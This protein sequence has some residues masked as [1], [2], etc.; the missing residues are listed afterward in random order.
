MSVIKS[1]EYACT[2]SKKKKKPTIE[3]AC[4]MVGVN[5]SPT[6]VHILKLNILLNGNTVRESN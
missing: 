1:L 4:D 6:K 5:V 2:F 3:R